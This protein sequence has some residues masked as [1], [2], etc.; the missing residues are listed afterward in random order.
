MLGR[1]QAPFCCR[2][3]STAQRA[4]RACC[5]ACHSLCCM[6][7]TGEHSACCEVSRCLTSTSCSN[8][9]KFSGDGSVWCPSMHR[10]LNPNLLGVQTA[11]PRSGSNTVHSQSTRRKVLYFPSAWVKWPFIEA[12]PS[13]DSNGD[14]RWPERS[15]QTMSCEAPEYHDL[16]LLACCAHTSV[17]LRGFF[18]N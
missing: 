17:L 2:V 5:A 12:S 10:L 15:V 4:H 14:R 8:A 16:L 11:S 9:D 7:N 13:N 6:G 3:L 18:R 1:T